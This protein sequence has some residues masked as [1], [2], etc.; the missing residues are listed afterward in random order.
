MTEQ[1]IKLDNEILAIITQVF[2][3]VRTNNGTILLPLTKL[4]RILIGRFRVLFC[5]FTRGFFLWKFKLKHN[6][7]GDC[8]NVLVFGLPLVKF[9]SLALTTPLFCG[10]LCVCVMWGQEV[11]EQQ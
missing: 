9:V 3:C 10:Y 11:S 7:G 6:G 2:L 5:W 1:G 4:G 8:G